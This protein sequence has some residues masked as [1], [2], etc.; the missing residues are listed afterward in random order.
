MQVSNLPAGYYKLIVLDSDTGRVEVDITLM[1]PP[2]LKVNLTPSLY[3]N[4][5]NISC[6]NCF[7]GSLQTAVTG[8]VPPYQYE[9]NDG[10][11][12]PHRSGL[13]H[14]FGYMVV[15][16]DAN[17][18]EAKSQ[19]MNLT[20]PEQEGWLKGG[21]STTDPLVDFIG[22]TDTTDL[23]LKTNGTE[24][25]RITG[26]GVLKFG[27]EEG[28]L[29]VDENGNAR[30]WAFTKPWCFPNDATISPWYLCGN[31]IES[32]AVH[33]LGTVNKKALNFRTDNVQRMTITKDGK[34]GI[35]TVPPSGAIAGYRLFVEDGVVTRDV[36]VKLG[37]WPDYVFREDYR[38]MPLSELRV[39]VQ[40]NSHLPHVPS[41]IELEEKGGLP[42]GDLAHQLTR[43][44]EEQALYILQLEERASKA[45]ERLAR[46]EQRLSTLEASK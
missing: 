18:C 35:G 9:W 23:V 16:L 19:R 22:T 3:P 14:K 30:S 32:D 33:F 28:I 13:G 11:A 7:N 2:P 40:R 34:V 25:V 4:D 39:F 10:A 20:Q 1:Q 29:G 36:L 46:L 24:R 8:G 27:F 45:E 44:I 43:T 5:Y 38:L 17:G 12:T 15:V 37:A 26:E 41:A 21:N 42:L 6:W 31:E